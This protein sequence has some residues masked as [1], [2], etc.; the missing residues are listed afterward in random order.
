MSQITFPHGTANEL[1]LYTVYKYCSTHT[2]TYE[3]I[4]VKH[5]KIIYF[6]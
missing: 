3:I 4:N 1:T 2:N 6:L 5:L